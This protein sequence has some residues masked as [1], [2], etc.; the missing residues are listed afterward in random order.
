MTTRATL[1]GPHGSHP[2]RPPDPAIRPTSLVWIDS[3]EAVL[4]RLRDR[5][6]D[7]ERVVSDVPAHHRATGHVRHDPLVHG[8]GDAPQRGGEPHRLE[9]LRRF[10]A[11]VATRLDRDDDLLV[12]GKGTVHEQL[13]R[14]VAADDARHGTVREIA[15][16]SSPPITERQLVA[17]LRTFAGQEPRR[18]TIGSYRWSETPGR[19]ASGE[20]APA[21]RRVT[22]KPRPDR[23]DGRT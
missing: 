5:V 2:D 4:V 19:R 1:D 22:A 11:D 23:R 12:L 17:R 16:E 8:R 13:A 21:P 15:C 10:V 9:H 6:A 20:A 7:V 18:M 14:L 3:R